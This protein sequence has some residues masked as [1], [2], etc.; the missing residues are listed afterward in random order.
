VVPSCPVELN[1]MALGITDLS[2]DLSLSHPARLSTTADAPPHGQRPDTPPPPAN[3]HTLL[4]T[5][6]GQENPIPLP[7][8]A[9]TG[10]KPGTCGKTRETLGLVVGC[11]RLFPALGTAKDRRNGAAVHSA[12][13][14][15]PADAQAGADFA[16]GTPSRRIS[17]R[18]IPIRSRIELSLRFWG[19]RRC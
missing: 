6:R 14:D 12:L 10:N 9:K 3:P 13:L 16:N 2:D 7:D 19:R 1:K 18:H 4:L 8:N 15:A 17:D 5:A 11:S